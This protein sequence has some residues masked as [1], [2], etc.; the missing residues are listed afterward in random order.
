MMSLLDIE[1]FWP[2]VVG[3]QLPAGQKLISQSTRPRK[4]RGLIFLFRTLVHLQKDHKWKA[5]ERYS[6]ADTPK[7]GRDDECHGSG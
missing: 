7:A 2:V 3:E 5:P 6:A 4:S 1:K